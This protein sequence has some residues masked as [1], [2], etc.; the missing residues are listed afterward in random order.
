MSDARA[1]GLDVGE[2]RIGVAVST[3]RVAVP[4]TIIEHKNRRADIERILTLAAD[5]QVTRIVVGLP[6]N[7]N[8]HEGEQAR[9]TR[10]FSEDLARQTSLTVEFQDELLSTSDA[11]AQPGNARRS[12]ADDRAAAIILQR[13]IDERERV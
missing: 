13:Y 11:E 2:K 10:R 7:T 6:V 9:L 12:P 5:Q 8:G 3:G 1:L 4:L